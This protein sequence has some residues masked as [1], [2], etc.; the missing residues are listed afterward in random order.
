M[1]SIVWRR[2]GQQVYVY[3]YDRAA[4]KTKQV[5]REYTEKWDKW[6]REEVE[7]AVAK[8]LRENGLDAHRVDRRK[9]QA[10]DS[11]SKLW[12]GYQKHT[13]VK[14]RGGNRRA[15]TEKQENDLFERHILPFFVMQHE[16]KNPTE[17]HGLVPEYHDWL[18]ER[19]GVRGVRKVLGILGRFGKWLVFRRLMWVPFAIQLPADV[20]AK[21]TPLKRPVDP[22][23]VMG[24]TSTPVIYEGRTY[25]K[26][27]RKQVLLRVDLMALLGYFASLRP[28][29]VYALDREDILMGAQAVEHAELYPEFQKRGLGSKM[30][31]VI[32]KTL[33]GPKVKPEV[34]SEAAEGV[35]LV[36]DVEAARRIR[37]II[38]GMPPGRLF[39]ASRSTCD[40]SWREK[41][42]GV[43][44]HDLRR[45]SCLYL[46][47]VVRI[48]KD[49]LQEHARHEEE[50]TTSL[51]TRKPKTPGRQMPVGGTED[52]DVG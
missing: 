49:L 52:S 12:A 14:K 38:L 33:T 25:K 22:S 42:L 16:R 31:V 17:W 7:A 20:R 5:P 24:F 48:P 37:D 27:T 2:A 45:A 1:A 36:W 34:K 44:M 40:R 8:W 46:G 50:E 51:Y 6:P 15:V 26:S 4:R 23:E 43:T 3:Y 41:G 10:S 32:N 11:L 19:L 28:E 18:G 21:I 29:E 30:A 47:R 9:L 13:R 39:R 35:V